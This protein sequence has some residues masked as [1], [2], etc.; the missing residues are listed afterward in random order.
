MPK[1]FKTMNVPPESEMAAIQYW[2][3]FGYELFSNQEVKNS[4][5]TTGQDMVDVWCDTVTE[6]VHHEHYIKLSFQRDTKIPHYDELKRLEM[7][8]ES[9]QQP[10]DPPA[11]NS[12]TK[13]IIGTLFCTIPGIIFIIQN[14]K[15]PAVYRA[16][17]QEYAEYVQK[18]DAI[19]ERA[20]ALID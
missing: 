18:R 6:T 11:Y 17:R 13:I 4:Y 19:A 2:T 20:R 7:E 12:I 15:Y 1:D 10:A 5:T 16:Y 8:A 14:L 3:S 9:I